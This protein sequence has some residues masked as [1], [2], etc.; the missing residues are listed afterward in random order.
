MVE[1][2]AGGVEEQHVGRRMLVLRVGVGYVVGI[3]EV[4]CLKPISG[5]LDF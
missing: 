1:R 4:K 2:V 3:H 5:G